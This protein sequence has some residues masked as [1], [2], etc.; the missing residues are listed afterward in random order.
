[1]KEDNCDVQKTV[2]Y[3]SSGIRLDDE[4]A[5][6][7]ESAYVYNS[8]MPEIYSDEEISVIACKERE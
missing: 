8:M 1:M 6:I 7:V 2:T 3:D 5:E 4:T